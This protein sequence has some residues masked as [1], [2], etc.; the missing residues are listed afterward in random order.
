MPVGILLVRPTTN[1]QPS[2]IRARAIVVPS[3]IRARR[4][5]RRGDSTRQ[6]LGDWP[7]QLH[8][9]VGSPEHFRRAL[10]SCRL[11]A[12]HSTGGPIARR[13][14]TGAR[15]IHRGAGRAI[16]SRRS[17]DTTSGLT[18]RCTGRHR[19]ARARAPR[20]RGAILGS[21]VPPVNGGSLDR[22]RKDQ[23]SGQ[24]G[25]SGRRAGFQAL[26]GTDGR[27]FRRSRG[28][29]RNLAP[30]PACPRTNLTGG[31][32]VPASAVLCIH[33][34][35]P[36]RAGDRPGLRLTRL[37]AGRAICVGDRLTRPAV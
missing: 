12:M 9:P 1:D 29:R 26:R 33:Q 27:F 13:R 8:L 10:S 35:G 14:S 31:S 23:S 30:H 18:C 34:A 5:D 11:H 24:R 4:L 7:Y 2:G 28:F 22:Q 20:A 3:F 37:G 19:G 21:R 6:P 15:L 25:T 17:R 16:L 32:S 36:S